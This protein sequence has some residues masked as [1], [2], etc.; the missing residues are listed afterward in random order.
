MNP[1]AKSLYD[2]FQWIEANYPALGAACTTD[3]QRAQLQ[4]SYELAYQNYNQAMNKEFADDDASLAALKADLARETMQMQDSLS[5][6]K[7]IAA[8]IELIASCVQV[9]AKLVAAVG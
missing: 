8:R 9:G 6:L 7:D 4:A 3:A 5:G 2:L 1:T